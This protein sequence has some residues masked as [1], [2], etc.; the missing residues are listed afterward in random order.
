MDPIRL[1]DVQDIRALTPEEKARLAFEA[2]RTGVRLK[3]AALRVRHPE[4]TEAQ[5]EQW[6]AEWLTADE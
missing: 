2:H 6:I 1:D 4:A 5:I 3:R